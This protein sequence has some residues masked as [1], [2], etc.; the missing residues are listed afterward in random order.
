MKPTDRHAHE[1]DAQAYWRSFTVTV[2]FTEPITLVGTLE[3]LSD[4][5]DRNRDGTT[6][7]HPRLTIRDDE[8]QVYLVIA[9]Q[10]RLVAE[11]V[12]VKAVVGDRI[13]IIYSGPAGTA[14]PGMHPTK[15]FRVDK[16]RPEARTEQTEG[17]SGSENV[18]LAA[19]EAAS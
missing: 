14:A 17:T 11:L 5:H 3:G 12:R 15:E 10:A 7:R 8:G 18:P 1:M 2:H 6:T 9:R 4:Q 13:R 16:S 19:Q